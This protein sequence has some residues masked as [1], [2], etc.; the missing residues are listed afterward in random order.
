MTKRPLDDVETLDDG[1]EYDVDDGL[2][3]GGDVVVAD[4][5]QSP[6]TNIPDTLDTNTDDPT[7]KKKKNKKKNK[8]PRKSIF[9]DP[10]VAQA[11][12]S[13]Q[14]EFMTKKLLQ[15]YTDLSMLE[16]QD[17]IFRPDFFLES[18]QF[19]AP[20]EPTQFGEWVRQLDQID[21]A[22]T[23]L[24]VKGSPKVL[25]I[26][27]AALRAVE[28]V[29]ATRKVVPESKVAKLF[30]RHIKV[31]EQE[32]FL[33]STVVGAAVGTPNRI[34]KLLDASALS[35]EHTTLVV[36]DCFRDLKDRMIV[37]MPECAKDLFTIYL[38]Y[39]HTPLENNKL[40]LALF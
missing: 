13:D 28:L 33:K 25:I 38:Q 39:L 37:D 29:A 2:T 20:R 31:S 23:D 1:L 40:R 21:L 19:P 6:T 32:R 24:E 17:K 22:T 8:K 10:S 4:S 30:A 12:S 34:L 5:P 11:S 36:M 7:P 9:S 18:C 15:T 16:L 26:T 14:S 35:L 3:A 27:G